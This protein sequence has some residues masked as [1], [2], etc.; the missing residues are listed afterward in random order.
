MSSSA[1]TARSFILRLVGKRN[2]DGSYDAALD[3]D[4]KQAG[5]ADAVL[6]HGNCGS[7]RQLYQRGLERYG[8]PPYI[9]PTLQECFPDESPDHGEGTG[10]GMHPER[11]VPVTSAEISEVRKMAEQ[12]GDLQRFK[13]AAEML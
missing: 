9:Y 5:E 7:V 2:D 3:V 6:L 4:G 12:F 11:I 1:K 13:R 10:T 8:K